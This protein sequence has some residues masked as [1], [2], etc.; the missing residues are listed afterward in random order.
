MNADHSDKQ[1]KKE[2]KHKVKRAYKYKQKQRK[3]ITIGTLVF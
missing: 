1:S 3:Q 2:L